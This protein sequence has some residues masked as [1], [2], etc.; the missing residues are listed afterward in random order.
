MRL[1]LAHLIEKI[2]GIPRYFPEIKWSK[3]ESLVHDIFRC[4]EW[5]IGRKQR[6]T[7]EVYFSHV[8]GVT[9]LRFMTLEATLAHIDGLIRL[10]WRDGLLRYG[11]IIAWP[12]FADL[13]GLTTVFGSP[14]AVPL[15]ILAVAYDSGGTQTTAS[16][17]PTFNFTITGSNIMLIGGAFYNTNTD[18]VTGMTWNTTESLTKDQTIH[19]SFN[20][21][22]YIFHLGGA[23]TGTHALTGAA[24]AANMRIDGA[25]YSGAA[26]TLDTSSQGSVSTS[27]T[28]TCNITTS[29]L[30]TFICALVVNHNGDANLSSDGNVRQHSGTGFSYVDKACA[31]AG[32]NSVSN[33]GTGFP[34]TDWVYCISSV[35]PFGASPFVATNPSSTLLLMG[36]G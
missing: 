34:A 29:Y 4:K 6:V 31:S 7:P 35:F 9:T 1:F 21:Y 20:Q 36:V 12:N 27:T 16:S 22:G 11:K 32:A 13:L 26:S 8:D 28:A 23:S 30:N 19:A 14:L 2:T 3:G 17:S 15:P 24:G 33:G 18:G 5:L 25:S 10:A